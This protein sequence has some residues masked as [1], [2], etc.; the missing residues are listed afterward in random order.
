LALPAACAT[1]R[2]IEKIPAPT[3]PPMPIDTAASM[4]IWPAPELAGAEGLVM[5]VVMG[6]VSA[7]R[8]PATLLVVIARLNRAIQYSQSV[9]TGSPGR[10]GR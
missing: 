3:M 6:F 7:K 10:A 8:S 1:T 4:P 2:R 9:F 5:P